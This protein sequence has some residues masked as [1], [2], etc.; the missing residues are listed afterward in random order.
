MG[1]RGF[2][3]SSLKKKG[4]ITMDTFT[5]GYVDRDTDCAHYVE[6]IAT[7]VDEAINKVK[8]LKPYRIFMVRKNG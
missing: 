8:S 2:N 6:V 7:N 1:G 4:V 3:P 5:I